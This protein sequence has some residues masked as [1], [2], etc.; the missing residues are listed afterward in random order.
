MPLPLIEIEIL[1]SIEI[2]KIIKK[3][4]DN[5]H[6]IYRV[7]EIQHQNKIYTGKILSIQEHFLQNIQAREDGTANYN[8]YR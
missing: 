1:L 3:K 4:V 5:K 8:M 6:G 2:K 7:K